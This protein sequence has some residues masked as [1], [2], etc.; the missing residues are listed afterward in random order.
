MHR[1]CSSGL[2]GSVF[3]GIGVGLGCKGFAA[4]ETEP[5]L[6]ELGMSMF[7]LL[8]VQHHFSVESVLTVRSATTSMVSR[9]NP[10]KQKLFLIILM[11]ILVI[12][13]V[14]LLMII[15]VLS[16]VLILVVIRVIILELIL[17]FCVH[18][19]C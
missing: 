16:V 19:I 10:I 6:T 7:S 3:S 14:I 5:S 9:L 12:N 11:I 1:A 18:K 17:R 4:H 2:R 13:L 15:L 8:T